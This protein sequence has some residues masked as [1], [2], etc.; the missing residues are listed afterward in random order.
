[1]KIRTELYRTEPQSDLWITDVIV[2]GQTVTLPAMSTDDLLRL[3]IVLENT[4]AC[5]L[6][7][8]EEEEEPCEHD[9]QVRA[10]QAAAC[11]VV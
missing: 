7:S 9:G 5:V 10:G 1:M 11:I 3:S 4:L 8:E 2:G 6:H